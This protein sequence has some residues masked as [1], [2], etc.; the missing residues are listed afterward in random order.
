V[1]IY[2]WSVLGFSIVFVVIGIALLVVTAAHG[3][4]VVGFVLGALFV[5]LGAGRFTI[6]RRR[7]Q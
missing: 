4:G 1:N 2:H 6:E 7:T 3:G 5:A